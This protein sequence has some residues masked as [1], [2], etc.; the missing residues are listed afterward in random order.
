ML[1]LALSTSLSYS[2]S[3]M[4]SKE[5]KKELRKMAQTC[6]CD[7]SNVSLVCFSTSSNGSVDRSGYNNNNQNE[8][9]QNNFK[10][11]FQKPGGSNNSNRPR[12]NSQSS[13][14]SRE[15]S[16]ERG[17]AYG[18]RESS[19]DRRQHRRSRYNGRRGSDYQSSRENS[20][21][22]FGSNWSRNDS[23]NNLRDEESSSWRRL[24]EG[25]SSTDQK[26][27]ELTKE[28][29]DSVDLRATGSDQRTLFDPRNPFKPIVV[30]IT[31][32]RPREVIMNDTGDN[33][34]DNQQY[35]SSAKP[36][37]FKKNS[38]QYKSIKSQHLIDE[39]DRLDDDLIGII[40][41]GELI[42]E[43]SRCQK[44]R[45]RI[46][47]IFDDL[48]SKDMRFCQ[49]EHV[50][51]YFWKLL[52]YRI[53]EMLRSQMQ[54]CDEASKASYKEKA[55]ETIDGGTK[56]LESLIKHLEV[57]Y[58]F[59][60]EE[61][62][63]EN[64]ASYKSGMGYVNLALVSA[65]KIFLF[66]GDLARYREHI[67]QTNNFG[68]AKNYYSKAQQVVPKNGKPFNQLALLAVYSVSL[69][70]IQLISITKTVFLLET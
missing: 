66:L 35:L 63:G 27:A 36:T 18:S 3:F 8:N 55:L 42:R 39:L 4:L 9:Y 62:V 30:S 70:H 17:Y 10:V 41:N 52:F 48:L 33:Y 49:S 47:Q 61:F 16:T 40:D 13:Y 15:N 5:R 7:R 67:N 14:N 65:Q 29:K 56:Y 38:E 11:P 43:W 59:Q 64:A 53:I 50:E 1:N 37:W 20:A 25:S 44:L 68:R 60:I 32:N 19:L 22:R 34:S 58:K 28:F 69:F 2:F 46:Q 12:R 31:Q 24:N 6:N 57:C 26:I 51:H 54:D 45:E 23:L 21:E